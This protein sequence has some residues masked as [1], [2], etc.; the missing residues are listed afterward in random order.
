MA[1]IR[2]MPGHTEVTLFT[3]TTTEDGERISITISDGLPSADRVS[4]PNPPPERPSLW[5]RFSAAWAH[6]GH[7][8]VIIGWAVL[9]A[10]L[11]VYY[12]VA[13]IPWSTNS[14][15]VYVVA[16]LVVSSLGSG[17]R[18][19]RL[20]MDWFPLIVLL[21][22]YGILRGYASHTLWG[23]FYRPQV[24]FDTHVAGF[25][26][27]PTVQLQRW[28]YRPGL[29][30]WDYLCWACYMTHFFASFIIAGVLWKTN[31]PKFRRY[32]PLFVGLTFIGYITYVLYPAMPPWMASQ[33]GHM[34][35][36][37]R[38][39]D[40][41]WKH[42]HVGLG[43]ALFAGGDKFDN[44]VAAMPSLH[45]AYTMLICLFFWKGSS[46]RKRILLAAYPI[47]MAFSLVYTGEH[48]VT[49]IFVGWIYAAATMYVGSKLLDRWE[50]RRRRQQTESALGSV[51][52]P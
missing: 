45:G 13:G 1:E 23:P 49:D 35:S 20:L 6:P 50:A 47:C 25:G 42:L 8:R 26:I 9:V 3:M 36:T 52:L 18:W 5:P 28:L 46:R 21:F 12:F 48:F 7:R 33:F 51:A 43:Q 31:Y 30:F 39:I 40:Q 4:E 11:V 15:L 2:R 17:V 14:V 34:P 10:S 44:N 29:H 22:G 38:I 24:W 32:V 16:G 27:D 41:V 37:T 19:K